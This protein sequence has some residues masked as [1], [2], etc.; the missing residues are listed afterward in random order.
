MNNYI[1]FIII[2]VKKNIYYLNKKNKKKTAVSHA[3]DKTVNFRADM[4]VNGDVLNSATHVH[5]ASS[6]IPPPTFPANARSQSKRRCI[7]GIKEK[8]GV[9]WEFL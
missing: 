9:V 3:G 4:R 1:K 8:G 7:T 6:S 5:V 2:F